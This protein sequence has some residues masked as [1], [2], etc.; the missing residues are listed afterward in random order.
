MTEVPKKKI[1]IAGLKNAFKLYRYI[2]PFS[3]EYALGFFF[4]LGS[5]LA[6]L[7]FPK[8]LGELVNAGNAGS[9]SQEISSIAITLGVV[10]LIQSTFSYFRIVMFV[11]VTEKTMAFLRQ[12]TFRHLIK[13]PLSFFEKH[14]VGEL[15]S[16]ISSD[17]TLLQETLTT[18][19]AELMRQLIIIVGGII[20][21]SIHI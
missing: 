7:A 12:E 14:R 11:N 13:L 16:R 5:S 2:K 18:T 8:L 21:V 9:L 10:L 1:T 20:S 19:L 6:N 15:N 17:V 4:L 3:R